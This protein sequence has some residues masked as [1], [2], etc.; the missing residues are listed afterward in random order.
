[1]KS[2]IAVAAF[3]GAT[4]SL[5]GCGS[6]GTTTSAPAPCDYHSGA[7]WEC[8]ASLPKTTFQDMH[9]G[10]TKD[11]IIENGIMTISGTNWTT[12][13]ALDPT[14]CMGSVNFTVPNKTDHPDG[15]L[16]L[17]LLSSYASESSCSSPSNYVLSFSQP[18]D[19]GLTPV[20]QWVES[21]GN[22]AS[23]TNFTCFPS[24]QT[25]R[26]HFYADMHDGDQKVVKT[27]CTIAGDECD[28][29]ITPKTGGNWTVNAK[30]SKFNCSG[31]V[32]FRVE[33]KPNPPP[34]PLL[35]TFRVSRWY[36]QPVT[37]DQDDHPMEYFIE[38]QLDGE[39]VNQ[40]VEVG[41]PGVLPSTTTTA[42]ATTQTAPPNLTTTVPPT[43]SSTTST[44]QG[45]ILA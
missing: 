14:K 35:A 17:A 3:S 19:A 6:S 27:D 31:M 33:G 2:V 10:D 15:N 11:V 43:N 24:D 1:M 20:N 39:Q 41:N 12:S 38:Y 8:P 36:G 42:H 22:S 37:V 16:T 7:M 32:D 18:D 9:D 23:N 34:A 26:N 13:L 44:T 45:V 30:I 21:S 25:A 28:V 40:W 29:E 5:Q 4:I